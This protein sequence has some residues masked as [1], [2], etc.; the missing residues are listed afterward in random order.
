[1][2]YILEALAKSEEERR[3]RAIPD[4]QTQH[5]IYPGMP[6]A[7][8]RRTF[9]QERR[10]R[11]MILFGILL[12]LTA[13]LFR[14]MLPV[15]LEIKITRQGPG[16]ENGSGQQMVTTP[17]PTQETPATEPAKTT[18]ASSAVE[19]AASDIDRQQPVAESATNAPPAEEVIGPSQLSATAGE[20][21]QPL[22]ANSEL[23]LQPAPLVLKD[24]TPEQ[25][26]VVT[27]LPYLDDLPPATRQALPQLKFAGHTYSSVPEQRLIMVN[28]SIKREGET[29]GTGLK[30]EE[31]T[32]D[33]VVLDFRGIRFQ[34]RTTG[35]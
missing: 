5:T 6:A 18:T 11:P 26:P 24:G 2:S 23:R 28:N 17:A 4:L 33:G 1:M 27:L 7:R 29:I 19:Q 16:T 21:T 25:L 34:I 12:V 15:A 3:Q 10:L 8:R 35:E 13:W 31:I 32:W 20:N 30:L 14:D 22:P 9:H